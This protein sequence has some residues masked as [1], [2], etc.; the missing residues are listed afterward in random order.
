[1]KLSRQPLYARAEAVLRERIADGT[2]PPGMALPAEPSLAEELGV[3]QGTLRR[4]LAELERSRLI[5]KVHGKGSVVAVHTS[6]RALFHFFRLR[7]ADGAKAQASSLLTS[8]EHE[9]GEI[10]IERLRLLDGQAVIRERIVLPAER[11]PGLSL[12]VNRELETEMYVHYQRAHGVTVAHAEESMGA[13]IA[14]AETVRILHL[15]PGTPVLR[16][17]RLAFDL[18][19]QVVERRTSWLDTRAHRYGISLA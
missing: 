5:V 14:D 6:E 3:S 19:E 8:I 18:A 7:R 2:W 9:G 16:I 1:M 13:E 4:A 12:P 15:P 17:D 11:F 10:V